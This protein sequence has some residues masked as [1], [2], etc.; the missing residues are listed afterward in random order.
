MADTADVLGVGGIAQSPVLHFDLVA[1]LCLP[2][3]I[4]E[5]VDGTLSGDFCITVEDGDSQDDAEALF[6]GSLVGVED[7]MLAVQLG[8][9]VEVGGP[10]GRVGFVGRFALFAREDVVGGDVDQED[11]AVGT[12]LGQRRGG[13]DVEL[14]CTLGVLVD[15][16][17]KSVC[18]TVNQ[19]ARL[20][21][22]EGLLDLGS[23]C[24]VDSEDG[25]AVGPREA[26]AFGSP[27]FLAKCLDD[28]TPEETGGSCDQ[29]A[30]VVCHH[31]PCCLDQDDQIIR[32]RGEETVTTR[33]VLRWGGGSTALQP[34]SRSGLQTS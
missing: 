32:R 27:V 1:L 34:R 2:H 14:A 22:V 3:S 4:H 8:L 6:A 21:R 19:G 28:L 25:G 11:V 24:E 10:R 23:R 7:G 9:A 33:R 31:V 20:D 12:Q 29:Y 18:S 17:G 30:F 16:V 5:N 15:L 26:G 13:F